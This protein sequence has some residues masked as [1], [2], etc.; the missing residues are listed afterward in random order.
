LFGDDEKNKP[1]KCSKTFA[2]KR[3]SQMKGNE[4]IPSDSAY[5]KKPQRQGSLGS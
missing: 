1:G 2:S 4:A 3:K 5:F